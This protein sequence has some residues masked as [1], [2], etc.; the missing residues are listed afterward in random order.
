MENKKKS[1]ILTV[2]AA[3]I[4]LIIT[5]VMLAVNSVYVFI[6]GEAIRKDS[7]FVQIYFD[8]RIGRD[9]KKLDRFS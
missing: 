3:V 6:G 4:V 5:V 8:K 1:L 2:I 7:T 9:L